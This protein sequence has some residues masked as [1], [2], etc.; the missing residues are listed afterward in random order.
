MNDSYDW[1]EHVPEHPAKSAMV[2]LAIYAALI[3]VAGALPVML[4]FVKR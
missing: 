1:H 3:V 4:A 2:S